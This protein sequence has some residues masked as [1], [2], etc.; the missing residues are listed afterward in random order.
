MPYK[1][2]KLRNK[3]EYLVKNIKTKENVSTH[4]S[5]KDAK[6]HIAMLERIDFDERMKNI[7]FPVTISFK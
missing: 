2:R 4:S 5:L 6:K 1:I 3:E 7:K